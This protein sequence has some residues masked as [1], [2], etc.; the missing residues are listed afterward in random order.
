MVA[1]GET[2]CELPVAFVPVQPPEAVHEVA[3][4][5][6]HV[7]VELCPDVIDVGDAENVTVGAGVVEGGGAV[8]PAVAT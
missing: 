1:D 5:E 7:N 2:D 3:L 8:P 6:L 4:I